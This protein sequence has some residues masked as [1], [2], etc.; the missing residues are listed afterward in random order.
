MTCEGERFMTMKWIRSVSVV[1]LSASMLAC[2]SKEPA[3]PTSD[4]S[5]EIF[6]WWTSGGEVEALNA[7]L[8]V[9]RGHYPNVKVTNAAEALAAKARDR[10]DERMAEGLPPDMFQANVGA[11][12][13]RW[14][15]FNEI[16]D[17]ES[18]VE[19]LN[20]LAD[21]AGWRDVFPSQVTEALSYDGKMYAVPLNIHRINSLFLNKHVFEAEGLEPPTTLAELE[22]T[23]ETLSAAGYT[24][25]TIGNK[26]NW[27]MQLF[28]FENVLPAVAGGEYY[29]SFWRGEKDPDDQQIVDT[30]DTVLRL[31]PYFNEDANDVDWAEALDTMMTGDKPAAMAVMGD[32][33][34]GYFVSQGWEPGI[35]F[36]QIP[37]PGSNGTFVFTADTFAMPKGAPHESAARNFLST[38]GS[39]EGQTAFNKIKGSIPVRGDINPED[40]DALGQKTFEDFQSNERVLAMSGLTPVGSI[41]DVAP[42]IKEMLNDSDPDV[43]LFALRNSY[44]ALSR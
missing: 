31:W 43:L 30:L 32:W 18:K 25:L 36:D 37:F 13:Q 21:A 33:A 17:S 20:S 19:S 27:T 8:D 14:V 1:A 44:P 4:T 34:K 15:L 3:E 24:C 22:S 29:Q 2:G 11:D 35:D 26:N 38:V 5:L 7:L 9:H 41:D 10:L 42:A 23:C 12:Q 39:V 28:T 16:D 40:F 6:S